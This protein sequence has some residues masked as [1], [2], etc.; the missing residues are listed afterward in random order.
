[1]VM[2][3]GSTFSIK[4]SRLS[5]PPFRGAKALAVFAALA[6]VVL[7]LGVFSFPLS[8]QA[9]ETGDTLVDASIGDAS[10]LIPALSSD[11][12]SSAVSGMAYSG[13][14]KYDKDL[15]IIPDLAESW[16]FSEDNRTITFKLKPDLTWA[17]GTPFTAQDCVFTWK[18]MSDPDTPTAYGESFQ[19]I[20]SAEAVDDLT[21]RV[22]YKNVL[23]KALITWGFGIMPKHL[24][25]G[26]D[27]DSSPLAR[28]TV[29][30]GPFQ[31]ESWEVGQRI[32]QKPNERYHGGRPY[33]DRLVTRFIPDTTTQFME[34]ET[35][36]LDMM[37][38][39]PDQWLMAH[40]KP[41]LME[42]YD[43]HSY[44]AFAYTYLGFN[45]RDPRLADVR[46]RRA[47]AMAI[48]KDELVE[49]V[50]LGLGRVANG[51]FKPDMWSCNQNVKPH[52]FDPAAAK[53]LLAEAGWVDSNSDGV[54]DKDGQAFVLTIATNQGN[55]NREM[56]GLII[57]S[58]LKDVGIE[59]KLIIVE[60]AAF[61]KEFL[62]KGNFE[63]IIMGWT[64]PMDPDLFDVWNSTKT[65][66][67][68]LNFIGYA[69]AEVDALIDTGRF[70]I[71][72]DVRK[73]AY[74][75]IQEIFHEE[76]PYVFLY[77]PDSLIAVSKRFVGPEPAPAGLT[78]NFDRWWVPKDRQLY[79]Q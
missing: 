20:E 64:I 4:P 63:A 60:W 35:G 12:A 2:K 57:Q 54:V 61:L 36:S 21:F 18:L 73:R 76:V 78:W 30:T 47:I 58:R 7:A 27:L 67:G 48:D 44:M 24:L 56:T 14:V 62:D 9:P 50:L 53:Q 71:D 51:P 17:D 10:N 66:P 45:F 59:V 40:E 41:Q 8:A 65:N 68:Q 1:M 11:T 25:E 6:A 23:A 16:E 55:R 31:L 77:V 29:G 38:L 28:T 72:Q 49:G 69:N 79:A 26:A 39:D 37:T 13:L 32:I 74:D 42:R 34:L 46:V 43:F 52:P 19:Q 3:S 5:L 70:T 33:L 75:R 15:K 22:T